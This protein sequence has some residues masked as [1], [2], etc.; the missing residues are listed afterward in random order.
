MRPDAAKESECCKREL[1]VQC[2]SLSLLPYLAVYGS[3]HT[4]EGPLWRA[5]RARDA[6]SQ[7][8]RSVMSA[9][10]IHFPR[11]ERSGVLACAVKLKR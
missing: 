9:A 1:S 3:L 6:F 5:G 8:E 11:G 4:S 10:D 7:E 2:G